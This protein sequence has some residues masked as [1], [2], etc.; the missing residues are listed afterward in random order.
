[1]YVK[2]TYL[3]LAKE[4]RCY[5][6]MFVTFLLDNYNESKTLLPKFEMRTGLILLPKRLVRTITFTVWNRKTKE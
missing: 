2:Y 3:T 6:Q 4:H 5:L 1:M